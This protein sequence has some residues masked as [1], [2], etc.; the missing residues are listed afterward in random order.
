MSQSR[1]LLAWSAIFVAALAPRLAPLTAGSPYKAYVDEGN[2]LHPVAALLREGGWDPGSY[3]YPQLP[4]MAATATMRL[5]A[6]LH[7]TLHGRP[8]AADLSVGREVYDLLEPFELLLAGRLLSLIAGL[9]VVALTGVFGHLL[10]GYRGGLFAALLAALAPALAIRGAVATVDPYATFFTLAAL[11]FTHRSRTSRRPGLA[12]AACGVMAGLAFASKYP[13]VLVVVA[14]AV[15]T[16]LERLTWGERLRRLAIAAAGVVAG[17]VAGMPALLT[18]APEIYRSLV[19][20]AVIYQHLRSPPLWR[21]ALFT[22]EWDIFYAPPELGF[23]FLAGAA[24]GGVVG[25]RDRR[26][27]TATPRAAAGSG[28]APWAPTV[29]GWVAFAAVMVPLFARVPFQPFRNLLPLVPPACLAITLLVTSV[30]E[31]LGAGA[32]ARWLDPGAV[33]AVVI[34]FGPPL[35][36]YAWQRHQVVDSRRQAVDWLVAHADRRD[37]VLV[38]R[39]LAFLPSELER[40]GARPVVRR[41][42]VAAPAIREGRPRFVVAGWLERRGAAFVDV[43][44]LP[45]MARTYR[46]RATFGERWTSWD[47]AYTWRGNRQRIYVFER[48]D[49]GE[50]I[51]QQREGRQDGAEHLAP[52][53]L[54]GRRSRHL[55]GCDRRHRGHHAVVEAYDHPADR[56][57]QVDRGGAGIE[58]DHAPQVQRLP[59]GDHEAHLGGRPHRHLGPPPTGHRGALGQDLALVHRHHQPVPVEGVLE[60]LLGGG[61]TRHEPRRAHDHGDELHAVT[62]GRC[63]QTEVRAGVVPG[64]DTGGVRVAAEEAVGVEEL[65]LAV[66]EGGEAGSSHQPQVGVLEHCGPHSPQVPRGGP[67]HWQAGLVGGQPVGRMHLGVV[68]THRASLVAHPLDEGLL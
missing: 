29:W 15:T 14:F 53:E 62:P 36:S 21:Q 30:R 24:A 45:W 50:L 59:A 47:T 65:E 28:E 7:E 26:A 27:A 55:G 13:A 2:L 37:T 43:A 35:A 19:G 39:E 17:A 3:M 23:V 9:G 44:A 38:L 64:L 49:R 51:T 40:M 60:Q 22:A 31:R 33:A 32:A 5:Y 52:P 1:S 58:V 6:P 20:Q 54:P 42:D 11:L 63:R 67:I 48:L 4:I 34:L 46:L 41:W 18:H 25:V 57:A 68:Q 10:A 8:L 61:E 16:V 66:A 12:A 56:G